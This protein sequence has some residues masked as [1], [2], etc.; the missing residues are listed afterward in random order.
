MD[1]LWK[2]ESATAEYV[3]LFASVKHPSFDMHVESLKTQ[4]TRKDYQQSTEWRLKGNEFFQQENWVEAMKCYNQSLCFAEVGTENVALAYSNRSACNFHLKLYNEVLIDIELAKKAN[5]P[6]RFVLN[7]EQR[8]NESMKLMST[9]ERKAEFEPKL[10]YEAEKNFPCMANVMEIKYNEE[11]GRHLVAKC[12]I[13]VGQ[14]V[15][16]ENDIPAIRDDILSC[17]NCLQ[18]LVN[19]IACPNCPDVKFCTL[20]CLNRNETHKLE[21]GSFLPRMYFEMRHQIKTLLMAITSFPDVDA[22]MQFVEGTLLENPE[23]LPTSLNDLKS[24]YHFFFKLST[25]APFSHELMEA[26]KVYKT[27]I[28]LP[29][30]SSRFDNDRKKRFLMHVSM[31]HVL[32]YN[33][34]KF[35]SDYSSFVANVSSLLNHSCAPNIVSYIFSRNIISVSGRPIRKGEQLFFNYLGFNDTSSNANER[36]AKL[37]ASWGTR[38]Q[39]QKF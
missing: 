31:H 29:K 7:L 33:T 5:L 36:K 27:A 2:K 35:G 21:C 9:F 16:V 39:G 11:F 19:F 1:N 8:K 4:P 20:D 22:L 10:S 30:V 23:T 37:K 25:S 14:T 24:K 3:D 34:N 38:V 12:D 26:Y 17:Y 15:L 28:N 13:P 32:V 6:D 18:V